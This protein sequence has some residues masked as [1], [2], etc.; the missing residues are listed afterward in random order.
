MNG[1]LIIN[2]SVWKS[3]AERSDEC[4]D[5][6]IKLS[7]DRGWVIGTPHHALS[8]KNCGNEPVSM[9]GVKCKSP[10]GK[11]LSSWVIENSGTVQSV[12]LILK[13]FLLKYFD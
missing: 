1:K 6:L 10:D 3:V 5:Q 9:L 8:D 13:F 7:S 11:W 4:G 2:I 12:F